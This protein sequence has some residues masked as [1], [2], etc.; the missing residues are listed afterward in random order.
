MKYECQKSSG[1]TQRMP[2]LERKWELI[3]I[4]F[5]VE[6]PQTL[7]KFYYIGVA[8]NKLTKLAHFGLVKVDYN[9]E[10]LAKNYNRKIVQLYSLPI[11]IIS[12]RDTRFTSYFQ[13]SMQ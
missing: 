7:E 9:A 1:M 4:D 8:V 11:F 13:S 3:T 12:D 10:N 5:M 6:L 2:K